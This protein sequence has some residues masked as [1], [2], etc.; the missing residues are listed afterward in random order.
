[1]SHHA[2]KRRRGDERRP[3]PGAIR[4]SL[5]PAGEAYALQMLSHP[6]I[7]KIKEYRAQPGCH[8][9]AMELVAGETLRA[10]LS[11]GPIPLGQ[12]LDWS[13]QIAAAVEAAH[14]K[15]VVHRDLKPSN[16]MIES[17]SGRVKRSEEHTS[18]LQ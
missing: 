14:A 7:V 12:V 5:P 3:Q 18:E 10:R 2:V 1:M 17:A 11:Q 15:G 6:G 8:F 4:S 16:I 9:L 13:A